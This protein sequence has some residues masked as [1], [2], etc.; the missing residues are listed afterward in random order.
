MNRKKHIEID[1]H[2]KNNIGVDKSV[3]DAIKRRIVF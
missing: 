3:R 2:N 1:F